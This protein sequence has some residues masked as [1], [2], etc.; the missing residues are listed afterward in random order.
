MANVPISITN[1]HSAH[2]YIKTIPEFSGGLVVSE[3]ADNLEGNQLS[4]LCNMFYHDGKLCSRYGISKI[5]LGDEITGKFYSMTDEPFDGNMIFHCGT[6]I[7]RFDGAS[8]TL[9]YNNFPDTQSICYR[10]NDMVYFLSRNRVVVEVNTAFE[11][12]VPEPYIPTVYTN[13]N[14]TG[15]EFE[16]VEPANMLSSRIKCGY[17]ITTGSSY[18]LKYPVDT[19]KPVY[20]YKGDKLVS[21]TVGIYS[22]NR[23]RPNNAYDSFVNGDIAV[24]EYTAIIDGTEFEEYFDKIYGCSLAVCY[25]GTAEKGT[26]VI[27]SGNEKH[28]GKYFKSALLNPLYFPDTSEE[29][30][31][32]GCENITAMHKRYGKLYF[33]TKKQIYALSYSFDLATGADFV[34]SEISGKTGCDMPGTVQLIDN[35]LVFANKESGVMILQSTDNFDEQN[36]KPLSQ[37]ILPGSVAFPSDEI[38]TSYDFD[39]KYFIS[40]GDNMYVWDYGRTAYY[41]TGDYHKAQRRLAFYK[42]SGFGSCKKLFALSGKLF[43]FTAD[44][45]SSL[46]LYDS[47]SCVDTFQ[48]ES[49]TESYFVTKEFDFGIPYCKKKLEYIIFN[50]DCSYGGKLRVSVFADRK[51]YY[52]KEIPFSDCNRKIKLKLPPFLADFFKVRFEMSG[53]RMSLSGISLAYLP[54]QRTKNY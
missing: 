51:E 13:A 22:D 25:G 53:G 28:P 19:S 8:V 40:H 29:V 39:R 17:T 21:E 1:M 31:A 32:D 12:T 26:R 11:V 15:T 54:V 14:I 18:H 5:T 43:Y 30:L 10:M 34:L 42:F 45:N 36:I 20:L 9:I 33:F 52:S 41:E 16:T 48:S 4:E 50:A 46:L 7:Y 37:N 47:A 2:R 24:I 23:F 27:L 3:N 49:K 38:S 35:S 44:E 6:G